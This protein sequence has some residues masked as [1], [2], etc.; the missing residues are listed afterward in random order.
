MEGNIVAWRGSPL[1]SRALIGI[2]AMVKAVAR[3]PS[4]MRTPTRILSEVGRFRLRINLIGISVRRRSIMMYIA[5]LRQFR[6][7]AACEQGCTYRQRPSRN[8]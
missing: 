7:L 5:S 4:D 8:F 6:S 1:E 2:L 3:R